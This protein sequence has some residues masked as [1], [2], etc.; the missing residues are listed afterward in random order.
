MMHKAV[1]TKL[2]VDNTSQT[3]PFETTTV[4][5]WQ[6]LI[7]AKII[8]EVYPTYPSATGRCDPW[9]Q[10]TSPGPSRIIDKAIQTTFTQTTPLKL[11]DKA[12]QSYF[13]LQHKILIGTIAGERRVFTSPTATELPLVFDFQ[14][15]PHRHHFLKYLFRPY[16]DHHAHH[17]TAFI[18]IS[19]PFEGPIFGRLHF[20]TPDG[21]PPLVPRSQYTYAAIQHPN[22]GS[23]TMYH[24]Y[25]GWSLSPD[26]IAQWD[27]LEIGLNVV[28]ALLVKRNGSSDIDIH[29]RNFYRWYPQSLGFLN[30]PQPHWFGYKKIHTTEALARGAILRSRHAFSALAGMCSYTIAL[31]CQKDDSPIPTWLTDLHPQVHPGW[32]EDLR[33]SVVGTLNSTVQRRGALIHVGNCTWDKRIIRA[34]IAAEVPVWFYWGDSEG[35]H[36]PKADIFRI[37]Q[38]DEKDVKDMLKTTNPCSLS[39][40]TQE[41]IYN[42]QL[43]DDSTCPLPNATDALTIGNRLFQSAIISSSDQQLQETFSIDMEQVYGSIGHLAPAAEIISLPGLN[44][45]HNRYGFILDNNTPIHIPSS[46][47]PFTSSKLGNLLLCLDLPNDEINIKKISYI[48]DLISRASHSDFIRGAANLLPIW[49]LSHSSPDLLHSSLTCTPITQRLENPDTENIKFIV[50]GASD[51]NIDWYL[52][53]DDTI[54]V[55]ECC[56]QFNVNSPICDI[57]L[58]CIHAGIPFHQVKHIS[59]PHLPYPFVAPPS[60]LS[61]SLG[62]RW[63]GYKPDSA[64]YISYWKKAVAFLQSSRGHLALMEGGITWRLAVHALGLENACDTFLIRSCIRSPQPCVY[65]TNNGM[66]DQFE[67]LDRLTQPELEFISGTYYVYTD[68]GQQFAKLSWWPPHHVWNGNGRDMGYWSQKAETWFHNRLAKIKENPSIGLQNPTKWDNSLRYDVKLLQPFLKGSRAAATKFLQHG[69]L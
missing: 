7:S 51:P 52:L 34:L 37:C 35:Y 2:L 59:P 27:R 48:Y 39:P 21:E 67:E 14:S 12:I 60:P 61:N 62:Y 47:T 53:I 24:C 58:H 65:S 8:C 6:E 31:H 69:P 45:L 55:L 32:L 1:Q 44:I 50:H 33:S 41:P 40:T 54:T 64:D 46:F 57:I 17:Y 15:Q 13:Q 43:D 20:D 4:K 16:W 25:D 49:D 18:P 3:E 28:M 36:E 42:F 26:I 68:K 38:P 63:P 9:A 23:P 22:L 30:Y 29:G 56:R 66:D 19:L 11:V 10:K 5:Q